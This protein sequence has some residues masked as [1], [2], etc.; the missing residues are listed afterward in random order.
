MESE[1]NGLPY[2]PMQVSDTTDTLEKEGETIG[3]LGIPHETIWKKYNKTS[4][5][6]ID[7]NGSIGK[8][9][10]PMELLLRVENEEPKR[11]ISFSD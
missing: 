11:I 10:L 8:D 4:A 3:Q 2:Y 1:Y 5:E 7:I 6:Y 9:R